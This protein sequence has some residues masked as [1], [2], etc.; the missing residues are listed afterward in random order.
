VLAGIGIPNLQSFLIRSRLTA[1]VNEFNADLQFARSEAIRR[2]SPV[3]LRRNGG[4]SGDWSQGWDIFLDPNRN[5]TQ[6]AGDEL[7]RAARAFPAPMTLQAGTTIPDRLT[8]EGSGLLF[9][10]GGVFVICHGADLTSGSESRSR[11]LLVS[12]T[13]R[14]RLALDSNGDGVPEKET[15]AVASCT[16]P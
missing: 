7:L 2:N 1:A 8:F 12:P 15:G 14:M 11:A 13:G 6:D 3:T 4:S 9:T 10:A 16:N 5:G